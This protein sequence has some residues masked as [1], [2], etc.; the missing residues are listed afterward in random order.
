MHKITPCLWFNYNAEEAIAFYR[1]VFKNVTAKEISRYGDGGPGPKGT[2]MTA[3]FELNGHEFL[4]LNGGPH[5]QF[6]PAF[7]LVVYCETQEEIDYYWDKFAADGKEVQCGWVTDKFGLSWQIV[8]T[9]LSKL[10]SAGGERSQRTV[11]AMLKMQKLD[12]A[13][14]QAAYDGT[15]RAV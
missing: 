2:V 15:L 9:V 6:T 8:P 4:A 3:L 13:T 1:T 14:L 5:Y 12:I 10:M 11:S 7:S